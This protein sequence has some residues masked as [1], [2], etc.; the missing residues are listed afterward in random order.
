MVARPNFRRGKDFK[1]GVLAG[2]P[3]A[4]DL[5]DLA[6]RARYLPDGK[7]K[8]YPDPA[9]NFVPNSDGTRCQRIA[10]DAWPQLEAA[11]HDAFIAGT[12][13]VSRRGKFPSRVWV[14]VNGV[15]HEA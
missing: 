11:L 14:Y 2:Y 1:R 6:L 5:R 7:H 15:L 4:A 9:W 12:V 3:P 8:S 13:D 10:R